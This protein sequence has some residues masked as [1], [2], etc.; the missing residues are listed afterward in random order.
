MR[1]FNITL[2]LLFLLCLRSTS[3]WNYEVRLRALGS[4]K[5]KKKI[6]WPWVR[7][8]HEDRSLDLVNM[9]WQTYQYIVPTFG[10]FPLVKWMYHKRISETKLKNIVIWHMLS[11]F[12]C[13]WRASPL[14][15]VT[16]TR[17]NQG[18]QSLRFPLTSGCATTTT[19]LWITL[20]STSIWH[21]VSCKTS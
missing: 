21:S 13:L 14:S 17:G 5:W 10:H 11:A 3:A 19:E 20:N 9:F 8:C 2:P 15:K 16:R 18:N 4:G 7:V 6:T 1:I 12:R